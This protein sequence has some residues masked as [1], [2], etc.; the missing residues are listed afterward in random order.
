MKGAAQLVSFLLNIILFTLFVI[1]EIISYMFLQISPTNTVHVYDW[2]TVS[3]FSN[4][5]FY[6][7]NVNATANA[8]E[9]HPSLDSLIRL[10]EKHMQ[11]CYI[12][13]T[14][15]SDSH[16]VMR[17]KIFTVELMKLCCYINITVGYLVL[18]YCAML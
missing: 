3:A 7:S 18:I 1:D 13:K 11:K 8:G 4:I 15:L 5:F 10:L 2:I 9:L 12:F 14:T 16:C 6:E 17:Y